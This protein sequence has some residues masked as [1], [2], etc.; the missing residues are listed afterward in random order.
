M[1]INIDPDDNP[2]KN[3][4]RTFEGDLQ[5]GNAYFRRAEEFDSG[6]YGHSLVFNVAAMALERY[7]VA[8]CHLHGAEPDNHNFTCLMDAVETVVEV[9]PELNRKIR[10]LDES[11]FGI[12]SLDEY[13]H[14]TP[15]KED[16]DMILELCRQIQAFFVPEEIAAIRAELKIDQSESS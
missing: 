9:P 7:L 11:I 5:D 16:T 14:G 6:G 10:Y 4:F 15:E 2:R 8:L 1:F 13:Y 3:R 12:C